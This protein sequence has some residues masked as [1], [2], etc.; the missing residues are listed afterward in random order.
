[1]QDIIVASR[2]KGKLKEIRSI[3]KDLD[4]KIVSLDDV[5][6]PGELVEDG[7]DYL[8]NAQIKSSRIGEAYGRI[9]LADD[10]GLEIDAL[11]GR[12]GI[13]S[14]RFGGEDLDA[15][16]KNALILRLMKPVPASERTA[17]FRCAV[18][19][20]KPGAWEFHSEGVCEGLITEYMKGDKGFGYD[21][22]FFVPKF[23]LTMAELKPEEK[24]LVSH[25][26]MALKKI[27]DK[28]KEV[29]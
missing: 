27:R 1:M 21:P 13:Y 16:E 14:A 25:R 2:N 8:G 5:S 17:R 22:I 29:L 20:Q 9:T 15:R 3:L 7:A 28:L 10:S 6:Y 18:S 23:G 24:N 12:P 4:L 19:I 26:A 11:G